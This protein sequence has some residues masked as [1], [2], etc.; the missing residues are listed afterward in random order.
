MYP[1]DA[2]ER[3]TLMAQAELDLL[4]AATRQNVHERTGGCD[5]HFHAHFTRINTSQRLPIVGVPNG[6]FDD[7]SWN[8]TI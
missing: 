3:S 1:V 7:A 6:R 2:E 5:D 4:L 8:L